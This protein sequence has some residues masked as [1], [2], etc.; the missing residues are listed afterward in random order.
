MRSLSPLSDNYAWVEQ[1]DVGHDARILDVGCGAGRLLLKLHELG[2]T[3]L[4]GTD[5]FLEAELEYPN[6]VRVHKK[7]LREMTG[8][9]DLVMAHHSFEHMPDPN[10]A[11]QEMARLCVLHGAVLLRV[12]LTGKY[13]WRHYGT[14][15]VQLDAPRHLFLFTEAGME[16]LARRAG[17]SVKSVV[18]DSRGFQIWGSEQYKRGFALEGPHKPDTA[19]FL[20][21]ELAAY[22]E[23][24]NELNARRDGD[25]ASF[26]MVKTDSLS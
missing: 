16:L 25:Q 22:E 1:T 5:P 11:L 17:L 2:F 21:G 12:P 23:Q 10:G 13:A 26:L 19:L 9:F 18:Y 8:S 3:H 4:E 15:W 24:A 7:H 20:S 14:D 6:G